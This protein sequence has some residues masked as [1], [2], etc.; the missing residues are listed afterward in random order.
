MI[1]SCGASQF[2][3]L[4]DALQ[5]SDP[6]VSV[7]LNRARGIVRPAGADAVLWNADGVYLPERFPFT[8][9]PALHQGLYYVQ[10]ASSM[11]IAE[12][13]GQVVGRFF[14][15][16]APLTMLDA[17]AAPGG[18]T[19]AAAAMLP[20]GSL[21]VANEMS[22]QRARVLVENARKQGL[23]DLI[24]TRGD[25]ALYGTAGEIFDIILVDAPCSGEGMMR[26][27]PEAVAQWSPGL[28][29]ECAAIQRRLTAALWNALRPGGVMIY[30]TC[31]FN[32]LE[33]EAVA[34]AIAALPGA[35]AVT[36]ATDPAWGILGGIRTTLPVL[37]FIPGK[38]RG[39]GLFMAAFRKTVSVAP[40]AG[41]RRC[42]AT[43]KPAEAPAR[44]ADTLRRW[45]RPGD[46]RFVA[47]ADGAWSALRPELLRLLTEISQ[48]GTALTAAGTEVAFEKG[49]DLVPA[50]G[51]ALSLR[52]GEGVFPTLE[53][54]ADT[55]LAYLRGEAIRPDGLGD[56]PRGIV[57]LRYGGHP[58]GFV[59][60][61]GSRAN[62]LYPRDWRVVSDRR[63]T[64]LLSTL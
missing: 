4:T 9:D 6:V 56:L 52:L 60:N 21:T 58:L 59:K 7:K 11:F 34:E 5:S 12:A 24:V 45:L 62:N 10:D 55:A 23:D 53:T 41:R 8:F 32:L 42:A 49:R 3:G 44:T 19:G 31:T 43:P 37:R 33:D 46:Y 16:G 61:L 1:N 29:D 14:P 57:L 35:E 30:S 25:A 13:V 47:T 18:K 2:D 22:P 36:V 27:E 64:S 17:C 50:Q 20:P 63:P 39:E 15:E 51:L 38:T 40:S 26:K 28:V 54:D 48:T